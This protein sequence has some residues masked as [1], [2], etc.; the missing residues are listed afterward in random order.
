MLNKTLIAAI[1]SLM[2]C[3]KIAVAE[4]RWLESI[5][6]NPAKWTFYDVRKLEALYAKTVPN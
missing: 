3:D 5:I 2:R 1:K 6:D 4:M